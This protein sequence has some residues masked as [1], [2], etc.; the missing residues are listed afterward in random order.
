MLNLNPDQGHLEVPIKVKFTDPEAKRL[1][2]PKYHKSGDAGADLYVILD[3]ADRERG[4]TVFPGE[5]KLL[6]TGIRIELPRGFWARITHRSSTEKRHRLRVVE[7]TIDQGFRGDLFT[8]VSNDNTFP[9]VL[10][11]GDRVAQLIVL[12]IIHGI[13]AEAEELGA[14]E[15]G[16]GGFGSTGK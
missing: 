11:H 7:G 15:R 10:H 9:V 2:P 14:S 1:G 8:Q 6:A 3:E 16:T 13:F 12:P 4:L 5:R